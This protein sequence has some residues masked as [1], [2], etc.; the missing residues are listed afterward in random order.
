M[1]AKTGLIGIAAEG[2][3]VPECKARGSAL[4]AFAPPPR[5]RK[6]AAPF[7]FRGFRKSR[8]NCISA[9]SFLLSKSDPLR[10]APIL[11]WGRELEV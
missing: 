5:R 4:G 2:E 3:R 10:W 6:N 1:V 8:E 11:F 7:R 9:A